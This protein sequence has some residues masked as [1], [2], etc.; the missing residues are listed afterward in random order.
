MGLW[1]KHPPLHDWEYEHEDNY[2]QLNENLRRDNFADIYLYSHFWF[3][4]IGAERGG[5]DVG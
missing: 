4:E 2:E 3:K 5:Q 1:A